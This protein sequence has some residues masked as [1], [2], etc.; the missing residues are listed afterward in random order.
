ME[1]KHNGYC[2]SV[3]IRLPSSLNIENGINARKGVVIIYCL[4]YAS[5]F[6]STKCTSRLRN[7]LLSSDELAKPNPLSHSNAL[8]YRYIVLIPDA[9]LI[10]LVKIL[11]PYYPSQAVWRWSVGG[12]SDH[13]GPACQ[14]FAAGSLLIT[15]TQKYMLKT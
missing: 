6:F 11:I 9:F 2:V 4:S 8:E 15:D 7:I 12:M 14:C 10:F 5:P 3:L 1:R 13:H